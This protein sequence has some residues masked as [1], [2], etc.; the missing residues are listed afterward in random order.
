MAE[1]IRGKAQFAG[2]AA[3]LDVI[4]YATSS[5][6]GIQSFGLTQN[7]ESEKIKDS[8][9]NTCSER[10]INEMHD[11]DISIK[12]IGSSAANARAINTVSAGGFLP[13]QQ[14]VIITQPA[15]G[16]QLPTCMVGTFKV[17]S[18]MKIDAK[19]A[20][21][22]DLTIPLEKYADSTQNTLMNTTPA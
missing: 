7:Y 17:K 21:C 15:T 18:G 1:A 13:M 8:L 3:V 9:G 14:T 5:V 19:N 11:A 12:M 4:V 2:C 22:G 10:T 20:A 16:P 6:Q